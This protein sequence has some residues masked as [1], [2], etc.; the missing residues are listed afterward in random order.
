MRHLKLDRG[1]PWRRPYNR[2]IGWCVPPALSDA[3]PVQAS[4]VENLVNAALMAF[5]VC[6]LYAL[7][8]YAVGFRAG[9]LEVSACGVVMAAAP[10]VLKLTGSLRLARELFVTAQFFNIAWVTYQL[11]GLSAPTACWLISPPMIAMFLAGVRSALLWLGLSGAL[12]V[13]FHVLQTGGVPVAQLPPDALPALYFVSE[14]GLLFMLVMFV[15]I[16]EITK[17]RGFAKLEHALNT[18]NELATRDELTG[19]HNRRYLLSLM[20]QERQRADRY[21]HVFSTCMFDI[22]FFKQINDTHGHAAGDTVLR[23]FCQMARQ[24]IRVNDTFGRYGGE[25]F[26][27]MLPETPVAEAHLL[28]E[29]LRAAAAALQCG[30]S[31]QII[32]LTVSVGVAEFRPKDSVAQTIARADAALYLAK[33]LGRNR[34]VCQDDPALVASMQ[35]DELPGKQRLH[36]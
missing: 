11:G 16:F 4:R 36:V 8:Y 13:V 3:R 29:R 1:A 5:I 9:A 15:L 19:V 20:E 25:E 12:M 6:P 34:V 31:G 32:T 18:I 27:L 17:L 14:I 24:H 2:F 7:A 26:I 10:C 23:A 30:E 33:S 21:G 35:T 22:D 28:A